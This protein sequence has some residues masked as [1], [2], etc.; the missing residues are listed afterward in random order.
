ML[1]W[2]A[3]LWGMFGGA[4][5]E[6][7]DFCQFARSPRRRKRFDLGRLGFTLLAL[8]VLFRIS[9]GA[10][11]ALAAFREGQIVGPMGA[12]GVGVAA[13]LVLAQFF[14]VI[15]VQIASSTEDQATPEMVPQPQPVSFTATPGATS[16]LPQPDG[17]APTSPQGAGT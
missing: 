6:A 9:V 1:W 15:P 11:L 17:V 5:V 16:D 10:G 12:V 14:K 4:A 8:S 3:L 2:E 7:L 13:P